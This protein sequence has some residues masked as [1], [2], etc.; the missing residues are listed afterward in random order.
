MVEAVDSHSAVEPLRF[1]L[2]SEARHR[3]FQITALTPMET[4]TAFPNGAEL[5]CWFFEVSKP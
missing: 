1:V 3:T 4:L 5:F 2:G